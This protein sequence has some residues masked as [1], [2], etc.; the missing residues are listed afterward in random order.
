MIKKD[1]ETR[2]QIM[3]GHTFAT[4]TLGFNP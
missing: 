3:R 4:T 2:P 1:S